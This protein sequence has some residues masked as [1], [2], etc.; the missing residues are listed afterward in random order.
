MTS[1]LSANFGVN[2]TWAGPT[3][4]GN[5]STSVKILLA[6]L[7]NTD[8]PNNKADMQALYSAIPEGLR[9][10]EPLTIAD[11]KNIFAA[12]ASKYD[13]GTLQGTEVTDQAIITY[14]RLTGDEAKTPLDP[15]KEISADQLA[16]M[17]DLT[18]D[19][20]QIGYSLTKLLKPGMTLNTR[21]ASAVETEIQ[22]FEAKLGG[23][24]ASV[25]ADPAKYAA[26]R[27]NYAATVKE[28]KEYTYTP[29]AT[30]GAKVVAGPGL[31][32]Q[33]GQPAAV[34]KHVFSTPASQNVTEDYP[35]T[36]DIATAI[37][38]GKSWKDI[39]AMPGFKDAVAELFGKQ[40]LPEALTD[41]KELIFK[42]ICDNITNEKMQP[43]LAG[44]NTDQTIDL[45][46]M[47]VDNKK[48][49][50]AATMLKNNPALI[51]QVKDSA[52]ALKLLAKITETNKDQKL[53]QAILNQLDN[54][55]A[56]KILTDLLKT[57]ANK[58]LVCTVLE[59]LAATAPDKFKTCLV[60]MATESFNI[61]APALNDKAILMLITDGATTTTPTALAKATAKAISP[62][63]LE[64]LLMKKEGESFVLEPDFAKALLQDLDNT[65]LNK[66]F[67]LF[68]KDNPGAIKIAASADSRRTVGR[69]GNV[70][71][72]VSVSAPVE[73]ATLL[74]LTGQ[75]EGLM[76]FND[77]FAEKLSGLEPRNMAALLCEKAKDKTYIISDATAK[78]LLLAQKDTVMLL[79]LYKKDPVRFYAIFDGLE[80]A[81]KDSLLKAICTQALD[82]KADI[83]YQT[84]AQE[85]IKKQITNTSFTSFAETFKY[86]REQTAL[87]TAK[88]PKILTTLYTL[89]TTATGKTTKEI[90]AAINGSPEVVQSEAGVQTVGTGTAIQAKIQV[91]TTPQS[92]PIA[93]ILPHID[94]AR[95]PADKV[96]LANTNL[97]ALFK[98]LPE[99]YQT[100]LANPAFANIQICGPKDGIGG[101]TFMTMDGTKTIIQLPIDMLL[102]CADSKAAQI[103][104]LG[105]LIHEI[106]HAQD[107]LLEGDVTLRAASSLQEEFDAELASFTALKPLIEAHLATL[108]DEASKSQ[109]LNS[110]FNTP[111]SL[112]K[113]TVTRTGNTLSLNEGTLSA[114][115][116]AKY[117]D[118]DFLA[119]EGNQRAYDQYNNASMAVGKDGRVD[120]ISLGHV[121]SRTGVTFQSAGAVAAAQGPLGAF[122]IRRAPTLE[123]LQGITIPQELQSAL[124]TLIT[125]P[126]AKE[127]AS[128]TAVLSGAG[129]ADKYAEAQELLRNWPN[130]GE[131]NR[132]LRALILN[133]AGSPLTKAQLATKVFD[134]GIF[135]GDPALASV[136]DLFSNTEILSMINTPKGNTEYGN[137]GV[138]LF[139]QIVAHVAANPTGNDSLVQALVAKLQDASFTPVNKDALIAYLGYKL[140]S[141]S[142]IPDTFKSAASSV[143]ASFTATGG[144]AVATNPLEA[145]QQTTTITNPLAKAEARD[146]AI[147]KILNL[148]SAERNAALRTILM[149]WTEKPLLEAAAICKAYVG[150]AGI[151]LQEILSKADIQTILNLDNP[152]QH[153]LYR[154]CTKAMKKP[155]DIVPSGNPDSPLPPQKALELYQAAQPGKSLLDVMTEIGILVD[156]AI[157]LKPSNKPE[158][159]TELLNLKTDPTTQNRILGYLIRSGQLTKLPPSI[160]KDVTNNPLLAKM[161]ADYLADP[162]KTWAALGVIG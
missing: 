89:F 94:S 16:G 91:I 11:I 137:L 161:K 17:H 51:N 144:A 30:V 127:R 162:S 115:I 39:S 129:Q 66:L 12:V 3:G 93:G 97:Q 111:G 44:L 62:V 139:G 96:A 31:P 92:G 136:Q 147:Q 88:T 26:E 143:A 71:V 103:M 49:T 85:L 36:L 105:T 19:M 110:I 20:D 87:A 123:A 84:L 132:A 151:A 150:E 134:L 73:E 2:R 72:S 104:A 1:A 152:E 65:A 108:T 41:E 80:P 140:S 102:T 54:V 79:E 34:E 158:A 120:D 22:A 47:M 9:N 78:T 138:S 7:C 13:G 145:L 59:Q 82:P 27:A 99:K 128:L 68:E 141:S 21:K 107:T 109:F 5:I 124:Q 126:V 8:G 45:L 148:P 114:N 116:K 160:L 53:L 153:L 131:R 156:S 28:G 40:N 119:P 86:L 142:L 6:K 15:K 23:N 58:S 25:K 55:S 57:S 121:G 100:F 70:D 38:N 117:N 4:G 101:Y 35:N 76:R 18:D 149:T 48:I 42:L 52:E 125:G 135:N 95:Y 98:M 90:A 67:I 37:R 157:E 81:T 159:I 83:K 24:L 106:T 14:L 118:G 69:I 43:I 74:D 64:M 32:A 130:I 10:K 63:K 56:N 146:I 75:H 112:A 77:M 154:E 29:Q 46:R 61:I 113:D 33:E 155:T 60:T 50:T 133:E 122:Y